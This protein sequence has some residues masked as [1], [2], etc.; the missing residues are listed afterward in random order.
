MLR[1]HSTKHPVMR[2][3]EPGE[4]WGWC[5]VDRVELDFA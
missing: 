1:F 4:S 5:F 3:I 2:P